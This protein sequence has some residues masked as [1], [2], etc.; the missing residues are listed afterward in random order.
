MYI[1]GG[2]DIK[3]GSLDNLWSVDASKLTDQNAQN[4][5]ESTDKKT[6]WVKV[7][8]HGNNRPGPIA[9]HTSVIYGDKMYLFGGSSMQKVE[10]QYF[11]SLDLKQFKWELIHS[12]GDVPCSRDDHTAV[13]YEGSMVIFGGFSSDGERSNCLYRYYFKD[14]KW[15]KVSVLGQ[16]APVPRA[17]H[18]AL[19]FGDSMVIFGGRDE[20][21]NK[22]NDIWIFNFTTY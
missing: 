18:S 15:E 6:Q 21:S 19:I 9:H 8:T 3:E 13:I 4:D 10:T 14:N 1:Y 12:R 5:L 2:H 22:L 16:E 17:G 7:E 11:Y 20:D